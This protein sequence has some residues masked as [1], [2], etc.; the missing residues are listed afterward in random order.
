MYRFSPLWNICGPV[1]I[2]K[3]RAGESANFLT[4]PAPDFFSSGSGTGSWFFSKAA[5]APVFFSSSSGSGS[6]EPK[7]PGSGSWLL[8]KF[9][10][11]FFSTQTSKVKLQKKY[12]TSKIIGFFN[13]KNLLF[14]L[15]ESN[16]STIS[17]CFLYAEEP[18]FFSKRLRLRLPSPAKLYMFWFL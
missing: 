5:P 6:R 17:L 15:K 10:K 18:D 8:V 16:L 3:S 1:Y 2:E 11:I 12:K 14:H 4:A 9:A 13:L 7:T